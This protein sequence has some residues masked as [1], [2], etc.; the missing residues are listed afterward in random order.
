MPSFPLPKQLT[1]DDYAYLER[2][3]RNLKYRNKKESK[4]NLKV[5]KKFYVGKASV[6]NSDWAHETL[7]AAINHAKRLAEESETE[8]IVVQIVRVV[9]IPKRPVIVEKV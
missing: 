1:V 4:M 2:H 8:Q 6:V 9:R 3:M 7:Q 5:T